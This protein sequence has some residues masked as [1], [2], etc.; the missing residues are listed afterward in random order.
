MLSL[1]AEPAGLFIVDYS[2]SANVKIIGS[3]STGGY[4]KEV[5]YKNNKVYVTTGMKR[6]A[7]F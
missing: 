3:Y 4:A 1:L 2:D 7:G 5:V 6:S